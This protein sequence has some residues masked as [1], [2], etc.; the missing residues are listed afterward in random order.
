MSADSANNL[1]TKLALA[2]RAVA[3]NPKLPPYNAKGDGVTDDTAALQAW[4]TA[5][6]AQLTDGTYRIVRGLTL[7]GNNRELYTDH[8]KILA[9][10]ANITALT[11]TGN[12]ANIRAYIDGNRR[13]ALGLRVTGAGAVIENGLYENFR[14][15]TQFARGIEA[16]T[17]GGIIVRNNV[18]RSVVSVGDKTLGNGNGSSRGIALSAGAAA[19]ASSVIS[20]NRIE[21]ITGEEGDAIHVIFFDGKANPFNA[22]K[23]TVSDNVIRNVSR[24]FIKI[25]ASNVNVERNTLNFDLT[26]PPAY[27]G[28]AINV[29]RSQYVKVIGN[30]INPNLIGVDVAVTG[31]STALLRG[32]EIRDNVLRQKNNKAVTHIYVK[33]ANSPII[34]NNSIYGGG[35]AVLI[36][37]STTPRVSGNTHSPYR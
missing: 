14:S 30:R 7:A 35:Q 15:A 1:A 22:G 33:W 32:I 19:T 18:I 4:L 26:T 17:T 25:Q 2:P 20:G 21:N 9:D 31:F 5:G 37:S 23:V 29:I 27:P 11:V 16:T 28:P 3:L 34:V 13:A 36:V 24:R 8:A 6:G 12:N 10:G